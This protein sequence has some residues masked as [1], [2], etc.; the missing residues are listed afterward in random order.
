MV[1]MNF[2]YIDHYGARVE[3]DFLLKITILKY[4]MF[5]KLII[6]EIG[7]LNYFSKT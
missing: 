5:N 1:F 2:W 7:I 3:D 4:Q 6:E